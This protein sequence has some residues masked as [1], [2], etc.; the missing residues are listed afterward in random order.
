MKEIQRA[1]NHSENL[2]FYYSPEYSE[3]M[4]E[5]VEILAEKY[6]PVSQEDWECG[7]YKSRAIGDF[8]IRYLDNVVDKRALKKYLDNKDLLST[9]EAF[10]YDF[11]KFWYLCLFILDFSTGMCLNGQKINNSPK[12][13]IEKLARGILQNMESI[14][15][16]KLQV[17][18]VKSPMKLSLEIKG[19]HKTIIENADSL[20]YLAEI[21]VNG[22][23]QAKEDNRLN[24]SFTLLKFDEKK[25]KMESDSLSNSIHIWYFATMFISFFELKPPLKVRAKKDS[26]ESFNKLL[27]ISKLIYLIGLSNNDKFDEHEDTLKGYLK[28]YKNLNI[29]FIN[30]YYM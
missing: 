9:I 22:L 5:Y 25:G 16:A 6:K 26:H 18:T 8:A 12:E 30:G 27:L 14:D 23:S 13:D 10:E 1:E 15:F 28:Q 19:K 3:P 2:G 17:A 24:H 21:L 29:N 11:E 7:F 20:F 4:L